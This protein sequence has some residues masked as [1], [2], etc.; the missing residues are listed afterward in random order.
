VTSLRNQLDWCVKAQA[1]LGVCLAFALGLFYVCGYRPSSHRL[2]DLQMEIQ[3]KRRQLNDNTS[4]VAVLPALIEAVTEL[5]KRLALYDKQ[6]PRQQ[7]LDRFIKDINTLVHDASLK[8]VEVKPAV[9]P[10]RSQL[11]AE[12][13]VNL[14]FEGDF[15][16]VFSFLRQ[17][18]QMQRLTRVKE[19]KLKSS[20]RADKAGQVEVEL[21]MNIYFAAEDN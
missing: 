19:L 3:H 12:Q 9:M 20:D 18:E 6:L 14:K 8:R 13:P 17:T 7:E 10:V 5:E 16:S 1:I 15:M 4:Q 21:S 11:F 2:A